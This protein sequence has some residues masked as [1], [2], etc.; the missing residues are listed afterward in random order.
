MSLLTEKYR[1]K[2]TGILSCFDRMIITGTLPHICFA[3]GMTAWLYAHAIRI[4]D[5]PKFAD[6][7]RH[8]IRE[9]AERLAKENHLEIEHINKK[10][11]RKEDRVQKILKERGYE[12][13]LVHIISAME[14]CESYKPWHDKITHKTFLKPNTSKCLH[15]YFYFI[16]ETL[17]LCYVRV[18]TWC[19]FRLQI[20]FNGHAWLASQL[21]RRHIRYKLIDNAFDDIDDFE[22]AQQLADQL[23]VKVLHQLLDKYARLFCPV[24]ETFQQHYHWSI[25]QAE[26]ATDIVFKQQDD[27]KT[28]YDEL[29]K[30]AIHTVKPDNIATFLG[31]KLHSNHKVELGNRYNIRLEG[32][33][34]KHT[35]GS[36]S[37]KMYDKFQKILRIE[38]TVNDVSFFRH[39]RTVEHRD[40]TKTQK[41]APMKKNIYSL[42]PLKDELTA[43]NKRYLQF[44]SSF[45]IQLHGRHRLDKISRPV[46]ENGRNY[47]GFNFFDRDDLK[48]LLVIS[49]GEF[50][51]HGFQNKHIKKYFPDES[52]A[53]LSRLL[54]RLRLHG[55]IKRIGRTY[56]YYLTSLGKRLIA[57]ALRLKEFV[58]IPNLSLV[59]NV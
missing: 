35:M 46:R 23:N 12:P 30:T 31:Q 41:L 58:L 37:I 54:K 42:V 33:R 7:L 43:S 29:I 22:Q 2:I 56:K 34:I 48:L 21:D 19:P 25:M 27:L 15:Y 39:Y 50:T 36:V 44:I 11:I 55:L 5:Y 24:Q 16:D 52:C 17:G 4:F 26:Y 38:T 8:K 40:G 3:Q 59:G 49:R 32:C 51:I 18:P 1:N 20:Y 57:A 28:L 10:N 6:S 9:N 47:R 53:Q 45:Q 14:T 13:G